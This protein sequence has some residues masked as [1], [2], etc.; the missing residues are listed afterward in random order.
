MSLLF[1]A[2]SLTAIQPAADTVEVEV[3]VQ[4]IAKVPAQAYEVE[5]MI[6]Q[7]T[8]AGKY[9]NLAPDVAEKLAALESKKAGETCQL[10]DKIG[11]VGNEKV[12]DSGDAGEQ[13]SED[14]VATLAMETDPDGD[15]SGR[16]YVSYSETFISRADAE[17]ALKLLK[18]EGAPFL[19]INPVVF[20]CSQGE[21]EAKRD[22][23]V[24]SKQEATLIADMLGMRIKGV[25]RIAPDEPSTVMALAMENSFRHN[26]GKDTVEVVQGMRVTYTLEK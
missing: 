14:V 5:G 1:L 19:W 18:A 15:P 7:P 6:S 2:A 13:G 26:S 9:G 17:Q 3:V 16:N 10:W 12:F 25:A 4:G 8:G 24:R 22:G 20:D 23:L 11:L 21:I